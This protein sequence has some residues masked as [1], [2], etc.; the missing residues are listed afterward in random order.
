VDAPISTTYYNA[1]GV[2]HA[3][4]YADIGIIS[5]IYL[6]PDTVSFQNL[7]WQEVDA[8]VSASG[9]I[10]QS[11]GQC[12]AWW[13]ENGQSHLGYPTPPP[14]A[15]GADVSGY[16]SQVEAQ[17]QDYS[18]A[19]SGT[20]IQSSSESVS[21]PTQYSVYSNGF[22]WQNINTVTMAVNEDSSGNLTLTKDHVSASSAVNNATSQW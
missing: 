14:L 16:G 7:W 5:N 1:S 17:D 6:T 22:G 2:R 12:G 3:Q 8:A 19:C 4:G 21:I 11:N 15:V 10:C 18:G 13:C 9:A 20:Q